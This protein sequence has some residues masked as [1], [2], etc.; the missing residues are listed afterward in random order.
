[1][2]FNLSLL[3]RVPAAKLD[4]WVAHVSDALAVFLVAQV[5]A[6]CV[7][8]TAPTQRDAQAVHSTLKLIC[9]TTS[10]GTRGCRERE[11]HHLK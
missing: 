10:W 1:M 6:V 4:G 8:I 9:M 5:H 11:R 2:H 3:T 7:P